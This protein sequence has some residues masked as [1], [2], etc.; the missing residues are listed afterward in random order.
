M[1]V[2]S[3]RGNTL[4]AAEQRKRDANKGCDKC[5]DCGETREFWDAPAG[6]GIQHSSS[7]RF[8]G[9]FDLNRYR[10]DKYHCWTCGTMWESEEYVV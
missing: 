5:P 7:T 8:K 6:E 4:S 3:L 1:K 2:T 10:I 9:L